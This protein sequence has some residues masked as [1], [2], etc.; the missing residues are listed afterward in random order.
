MAS[1]GLKQIARPVETGRAIF[2]VG[3]C[4]VA[5]RQDPT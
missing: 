1:E 4:G 3:A 2:F 5:R